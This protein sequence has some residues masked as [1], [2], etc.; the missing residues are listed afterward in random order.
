MPV[1]SRIGSVIGG[2]RIDRELGRGGMGVVYCA[3]QARL[4]RLVALKLITPE[5]AGDPDFRQRFE[6]ESR[7]AASIEHPNVIPV[8]EAGEADGVLYIVMRYVEGTD[9]R[10]MIRRQG[11]LD[12]AR[13][14]DIVAQVGT[15]LDAAHSRGLVHRDIKPANILVASI[16]ERDHA[17]LTDFGLTKRISST[18]GPTRTG[19]WVGTADYVAPEQ[20]EA[21]PVD[22]RTDVYSLGCVLYQALTGEVPYVRDSEVATMFAHLQEPPPSVCEAAPEVPPQ[23]DEVVKRAMAKNPDDRYPSAGDLGRAALAAAEHS[24]PTAPERSVA[25]G[26]AAPGGHGPAPPTVPTAPPPETAPTAG[27]PT[28]PLP[29]VAADTRAL[30]RRRG[31]GPLI[32]LAAGAAVA[33]IAAVALLAGGG[34]GDDAETPSPPPTNAGNKQPQKEQQNQRD[35]QQTQ[36]EEQQQTQEQQQPPDDQAATAAYA[37]YAADDYTAEYPQGWKQVSDDVLKTTYSETKWVSPDGAQSVLIDH[38]PGETVAPAKK[39]AGL[40]RGA[41]ARTPG[42]KLISMEE[43][44][45]GEHPAVEWTFLD[46]SARKIDIFLNTGSDGFAVLGQGARFPE[47]IEATRHVAASIAP[48]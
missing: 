46:G 23:F 4:G 34:G 9:L 30:P 22:A 42:Y 40:E 31:R 45:A 3:E 21:R 24:L 41:D 7:L 14:A 17:Y 29:P 12:P 13:A 16:S 10:A 47:V 32:A 44:T 11:R 43:T 19:Q 39:A 27:L 2:Y 37:A 36:Q 15:A 38:S 5:L 8:H 26:R 25:T 33:A 20:I 35:Q 6:R 18:G 28:Q 1:D 48:R